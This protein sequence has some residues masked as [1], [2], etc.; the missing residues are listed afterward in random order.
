MNSSK[1]DDIPEEVKDRLLH[2]AGK[3]MKKYGVEHDDLV[4][5][6]LNMITIIDDFYKSETK[7]TIN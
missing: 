3:L 4:E 7:E 1:F 6:M 2:V 5:F